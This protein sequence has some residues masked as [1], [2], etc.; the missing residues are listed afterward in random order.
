MV[1]NQGY[2]I[3]P[4]WDKSGTFSDTISVYFGSSPNQ[5]VLKS[6]I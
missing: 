5:N 4:K 2:H 1:K 3:G 6:E